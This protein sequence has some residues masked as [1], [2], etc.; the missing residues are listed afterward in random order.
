MSCKCCRLRI[1]LVIVSNSIEYN[2]KFDVIVVMHDFRILTCEN[3][4]QRLILTIRAIGVLLHLYARM[5]V[6]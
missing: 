6:Q 1:T 4:F 2:N 5:N 3:I